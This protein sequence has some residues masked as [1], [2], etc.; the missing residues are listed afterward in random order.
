MFVKEKNSPIINI[1]ADTPI[2][3]ERVQKWGFEIYT[4]ETE[5][6]H[7]GL[8]YVKGQAPVEPQ[9]SYIEKR[10]EAY[11]KIED[12]LDMIYWDKINNTNLWQ[13]KIAEIKEKYPKE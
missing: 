7:N 4:G 8:L 2:N 6:G 1:W 10:Q 11:P 13:S 3:Q 12:Q 5:T 9:K